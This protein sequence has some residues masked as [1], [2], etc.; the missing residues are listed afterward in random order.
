MFR[1]DFDWFIQDS[2][3]SYMEN[4]RNRSLY[5][6]KLFDIDSCKNICVKRG[7]AIIYLNNNC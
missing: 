7:K 4:F 1:D 2:F 5:F 3:F 6:R